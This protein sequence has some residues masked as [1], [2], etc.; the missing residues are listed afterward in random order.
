MGLLDRIVLL[1]DDDDDARDAIAGLLGLHGYLPFRVATG[2]E[3]LAYLG[4]GLRPCA[5]L[6]NLAP[7]T[8]L[9]LRAE[10]VAH[11]S[12]AH[13]PVIMGARLGTPP[14]FAAA[15]DESTPPSTVNELLGLLREYCSG[16]MR[17]PRSHLRLV[18]AAPRA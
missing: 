3:A 5:I 10:Q 11:P 14:E 15:L 9:R 2:E 12:W 7:P 4:M 8:A 18:R 17:A 1:V 16:R 6:V 13:I